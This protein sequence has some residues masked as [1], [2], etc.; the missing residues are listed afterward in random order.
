MGVCVG[1]QG[2]TRKAQDSSQHCSSTFLPPPPLPPSQL[3]PQAAKQH[4]AMMQRAGGTSG[5]LSPRPEAAAGAPAPACGCPLRLPTN[6]RCASFPPLP[7]Y[8][9]RHQHSTGQQSRGLAAPAAGCRRAQR[10][11]WGPRPCPWRNPPAP[12]AGSLS[13]PT[14]P[15]QA[16]QLT[17]SVQPHLQG[18]R[19]AGQSRGG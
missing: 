13:P 6:P 14:A 16:L 10:R 4:L 1:A 11:P 5:R 7:N 18:S 9:L 8:S 15:S 12:C 3:L 19:G 2:S 17:R